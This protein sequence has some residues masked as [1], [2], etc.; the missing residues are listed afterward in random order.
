[1]G[2]TAVSENGIAQVARAKVVLLPEA[3]D[4]GNVMLAILAQVRAVGV[5]D[6]GR[7]IEDALLFHFVDRHHEDH[8]RLAREILHQLRGRPGNRF[9]VG[10]V[11][12]VLH[13]AEVR[14][15]EEFLEAEHLGASIGGLTGQGDVG[16]DHR[17]FVARPLCL[18]QRGPHHLVGPA[19]RVTHDFP[20]IAP[21]STRCGY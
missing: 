7:V 6:D 1:M 9:G 8:V 11:L 12:G 17:L 4:L 3:F 16:R 10:E 18:Y 14:S 20:R 15:V 5:D 19:L 2:P 21:I 13:L